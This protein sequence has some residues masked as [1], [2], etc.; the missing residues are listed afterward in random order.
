M[1]EGPSSHN[2]LNFPSSI[3]FLGLNIPTKKFLSH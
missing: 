1:E 3:Y 2:N